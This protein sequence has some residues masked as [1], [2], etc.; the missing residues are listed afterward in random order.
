[1]ETT[2]SPL[3]DEFQRL[4]IGIGY[5]P[6]EYHAAIDQLEDQMLASAEHMLDE[7][8]THSFTDKVY[9]RQMFAPAGAIVTTRIHK[10]KH[11]FVVLR[12]RVSVFDARDGSINHIEAPYMGVTEP[13]TRRIAFVHEDT[14]WVTFHV[15]EDNETDIERL[16][17]RYFAWSRLVNGKNIR[18]LTQA[19]KAALSL[20]EAV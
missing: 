8:I 9:I 12:G 20:L 2:L 1:M 3:E 6:S 14:L 5:E 19:A 10:V 13:G 16:E 17:E 11:P 15:N 7:D 18:E 4:A